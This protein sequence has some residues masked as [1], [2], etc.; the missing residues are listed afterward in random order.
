MAASVAFA[1][2][3]C[4]SQSAPPSDGVTAPSP[5]AGPRE[6][7]APARKDYGE[8]PAYTGELPSLA[9]LNLRDA[10]L[11][12]VWSGLER[13]RAFTFI[14]DDEV[15]ITEIGG[16]L[17]RHRFGSGEVV[18]VA[19][20]P[21][22]LATH[23]QQGLLDVATHPDFARNRRIYLT[24]VK[25]DPE[26]PTYSLT[27][28]ATARLE[29]DRLRGLEILLEAGPYSWSPANFGGAM[30]FGSDGHLYLS[31]GD[32]GEGD[33][34]QD[35]R[36]LQGKILRLTGDGRVPPDNP[37][38]G[39][40]AIDDRIYALGVRNPQGL[41]VDP[42]TG[43]LYEAEHGPLGGDEVNILRAG[44]NYGWPIIT[45]G[46]NYTTADIGI[47]THARDME[48][49]IWYWTPSIAVSPLVVYR[50]AMFPEWEGDLLVGALKGQK[51]VRLDL[52]GGRVRS[53]QSFLTELAA[54][55]RDIEV[56][57]DG[58]VYVLTEAGGLHRLHRRPERRPPPGAPIPPAELYRLVCA[59]CHATGAYEAPNPELPGA[60]DAARAAPREQ[61]WRRTLEGYGRMPARGLCDV[62]SDEHLRSIV[63]WMLDEA[64]PSAEG[65]GDGDAAAAERSDGE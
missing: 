61:A 39:D 40:P 16:R 20:V 42:A 14:A 6:P 62:C 2:G 59:G 47:G 55:I 54:R 30:V 52:D 12:T 45:Y 4:G 25:A 60:L 21:E 1:L 38:I 10:F 57:P 23:P 50:G 24:F 48:Q 35:G 15:L 17:L 58:S 19:G 43:T 7:A 34:A 13:P 41:D 49:P 53:A 18:P 3:A 29:E 33:P 36:R 51:L 64:L 65:P 22:V 46:K 37:F 56:A 32:R 27:A 44:A 26:A 31:V 9:E 11:D 5:A 63:D 28:L 8:P